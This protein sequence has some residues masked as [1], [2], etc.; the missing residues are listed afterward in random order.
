[1]VD[2]HTHILHEVDDGSRSVDETINL[3]FEAVNAGF[4][5][6]ICTSHYMEGYYTISVQERAK[7]ILNFTNAIE[8]LKLDLKLYIGNE[9][10]ITPNIIELINNDKACTINNTKYILFELPFDSVPVQLFKTVD[11]IIKN[12][13]VPILAH[14]ERYTA[15]YQKPQYLF[16]LASNRSAYAIEFW[17]F[18]WSIWKSCKANGRK[19]IK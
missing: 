7:K 12:G 15:F 11:E 6:I 13:F 17:K 3:L 10:Y 9:I 14:P 18:Y 4:N 1:M 19:I 16:E 5:K 2:F 8:D